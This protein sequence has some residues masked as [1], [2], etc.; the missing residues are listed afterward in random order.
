M[1]APVVER[2]TD[3]VFSFRLRTATAADL[4]RVNDL[5][6][7]ADLPVEGVPVDLD[8][9]L[10]AVHPDGTIIGTGGLERYGTTALLRSTV[11][12]PAYQTCGVGGALVDEL[13]RRAE[14]QGAA[15]IVLLTTTAQEWFPRFGFSRISR[16]DVPEP[17]LASVEF[18]GA[19]PESAVVMRRPCRRGD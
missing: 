9:F 19:C 18:R 5:L 2:R 3:R 1:T 15:D 7:A 16:Q 12:D 4:S 10:V 17:A 6:R 11:V 14:A 8:G 13:L